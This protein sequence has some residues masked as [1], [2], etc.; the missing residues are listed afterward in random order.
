MPHKGSHT[1]AEALFAKEQEADARRVRAAAEREK[2]ADEIR[3]RAASNPLVAREQESQQ[4]VRMSR[5]SAERHSARN[6][7]RESR[8]IL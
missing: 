3:Q 7:R 2:T 1:K 8:C 5:E 4:Q 6:R